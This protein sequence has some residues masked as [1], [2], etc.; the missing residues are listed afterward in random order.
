MKVVEVR[1]IFE[2]LSKL[3]LNKFTKEVRI[4]VLKIHAD[5]F[6]CFKE[7]EAKIEEIRK[8]IFTDED[9]S[10][11][12]ESVNNKTPLSKEL[13][14]KQ[15]EYNEVINKLFEDECELNITK[16][17]QSD[18]I[19]CLVNSEIEFTPVDIIRIKPILK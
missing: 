17:S 3:K 12:Q 7:Q 2:F 18:F 1:T 8:K 11:I 9:I 16:I 15:S 13:V 14:D 4:A 19:E 6:T 10:L 5:M